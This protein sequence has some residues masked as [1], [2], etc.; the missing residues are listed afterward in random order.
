MKFI[1]RANKGY[2]D[3]IEAAIAENGIYISP[4]IQDKLYVYI[5]N[6]DLLLEV[7]HFELLRL[8][9]NLKK[10]EETPLDQ[11]IEHTRAGISLTMRFKDSLTVNSTIGW[12]I[13]YILTTFNNRP[14]E[15]THGPD[16]EYNDC[17][18]TAM[19]HLD[20]VIYFLKIRIAENS[21]I[22]TLYKIFMLNFVN[23]LIFYQLSRKF[24]LV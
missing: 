15:I 23:E 16:C 3:E 11:K 1:K 8:L 6:N 18:Y 5:E 21:I 9:N 24:K 20:D 13:Q 2:F 4:Y 10:I 19:H 7:E 22:P 14:A 17:V 12:G